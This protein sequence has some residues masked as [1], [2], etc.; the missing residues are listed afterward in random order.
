MLELPD[1]LPLFP[2]PNCVLLPRA[3]L[4]LHVFEERYRCMTRDV[5]EGDRLIGMAWLK[6]CSQEQYVTLHAPIHPVVGVGRIVKIENLPDGRF[7]FLLQG[8]ERVIVQSENSTGPYR[9]AHCRRIRTRD[10]E[11]GQACRVLKEL[12]RQLESP[13]LNSLPPL[14]KMHTL[15]ECC[16]LS[17]SEKL[18]ALASVVM[19]SCE[20]KQQMLSMGCLATRAELVFV[21]L[22]RL[23]QATCTAVQ[24]TQVARQRPGECW[25]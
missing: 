4:P 1:W 20:E 5:L 18:D 9:R 17:L 8:V 13:G 7:N 24:P 25:N 15:L 11:P 2:L 21:A 6:P 3:I 22:R 12:K 16:T 14:A 10:L 19:T 23:Q